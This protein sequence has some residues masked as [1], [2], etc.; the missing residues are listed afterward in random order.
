MAHP[1][2]KKKA[3][4][5]LRHGEVRGHK[6]SKK[7]KG[8]FGAIAGGSPLRRY[9]PDVYNDTALADMPSRTAY[10]ADP[11][12]LNTATSAKRAGGVPG[13]VAQTEGTANLRADYK[14][15]SANRAEPGNGRTRWGGVDSYNDTKELL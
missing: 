8:L 3:R 5:I 1:V 13:K 14:S 4:E 6:L 12:N 9:S 10:H 15:K 7:Q 2:S 11:E